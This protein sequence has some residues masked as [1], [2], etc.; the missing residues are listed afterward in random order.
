MYLNTTD[1]CTL[2]RKC[3]EILHVQTQSC[4]NT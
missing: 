4:D 2:A 1:R 3:S